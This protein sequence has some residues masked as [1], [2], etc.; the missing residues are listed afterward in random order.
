MWSPTKVSRPNPFDQLEELG[1]QPL[2]ESEALETNG[3]FVPLLAVILAADV[4]LTAAMIGA[5][6]ALAVAEKNDSGVC[7]AQ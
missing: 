1:L 3:G 6:A 2:S 4:A 5:W 7:Y